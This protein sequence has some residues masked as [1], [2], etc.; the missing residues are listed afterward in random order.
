MVLAKAEGQK[1]SGHFMLW[2][3]AEIMSM[4]DNGFGKLGQ[5]GFYVLSPCY[6]A[7]PP[8]AMGL[9]SERLMGRNQKYIPENT[10]DQS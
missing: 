10:K 7:Q 3:Q 2:T 1:T 9:L 6:K 8:K 4:M 5:K